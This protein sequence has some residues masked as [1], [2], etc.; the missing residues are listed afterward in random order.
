M[1]QKSLLTRSSGKAKNDYTEYSCQALASSLFA[2]STTRSESPLYGIG[3]GPGSPNSLTW[4]WETHWAT[5]YPSRPSYA[6]DGH[7][8]PSMAWRDSPLTVLE[9]ILWE[10]LNPGKKERHQSRPAAHP[11]RV[12]SSRTLG[13]ESF[14]PCCTILVFFQKGKV[15]WQYKA[16]Y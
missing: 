4:N 1:D 5:T 12:T 9:V 16:Y 11:L 6:M 10:I 3:T 14:H 7:T 13:C 2:P 8:S 15:F